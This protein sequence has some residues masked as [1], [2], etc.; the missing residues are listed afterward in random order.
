MRR[1]AIQHRR[2]A[3]LDRSFYVGDLM[4][5]F[6]NFPS[7][8]YLNNLKI[9]KQHLYKP[10]PFQMSFGNALRTDFQVVLLYHQRQS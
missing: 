9:Q 7:L 6:P 5:Y 1:D 8:S 2:V 4:L 10:L 3:S